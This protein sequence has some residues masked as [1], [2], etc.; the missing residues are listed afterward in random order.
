MRISHYSDGSSRNE[1]IT[2][3][4]A[5]PGFYRAYWAK[6]LPNGTPDPDDSIVCPVIGYCSPG[7]VQRTIGAAVREIQRFYPH[8]PMFRFRRGKFHKVSK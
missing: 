7:G 1:A 8:E 5:D 2:I 3:L 4:D 6:A